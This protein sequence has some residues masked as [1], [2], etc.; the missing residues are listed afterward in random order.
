[1]LVFRL[2]VTEADMTSTKM[3]KAAGSSSLAMPRKSRTVPIEQSFATLKSTDFS[4]MKIR[5]SFL[6]WLKRESGRRGLFLYEVVEEMATVALAGATP[7]SMRK[8]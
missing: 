1:M 8:R 2:F 7:W 6:A 5:S 4:T 3:L